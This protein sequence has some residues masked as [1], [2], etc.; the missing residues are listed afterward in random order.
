MKNPWFLFLLICMSAPLSAQQFMFGLGRVS[1]S[2]DYKDSQGNGLDN[3]FPVSNFSYELGYRTPLSKKVFVSGIAVLTRYG[4]FGSDQVYNNGYSW[5]LKYAGVGA[6][7]DLEFY[8]KRGLALL[9]SL[10]AEAQFLLQGVQ[11]INNQ[12]FRLRGEE[13]FDRPFL[14]VRPG[15]GLN[16]CLSRHLA[17]MVRYRYG[18]GFPIGK[19]TDP[20]I[21]RINS[22]TISIGLLVNLNQC[23]YCY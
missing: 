23:N 6:E 13:Q 1:S 4:S 17:F 5:D 20:E 2:F 18:K 8:Q 12:V 10:S 19:S 9:A 22:H 14:F 15:L 7:L 3:L 16:Y 21:L 11:Q